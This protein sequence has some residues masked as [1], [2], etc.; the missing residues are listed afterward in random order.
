MKANTLLL[1]IPLAIILVMHSIPGMLDGGIKQFGTMFLN[2]LCFSP[3][4]IY[5]ASLIKLSHV[6]A[7]IAL[8]LN[9]YLRPAA[10]GTIFVLFVGIITVHLES[11][12]FVVG[13]GSNGVE[14]NFLLIFVWLYLIF[15][16]GR[17]QQ[18][19]T[20]RSFFTLW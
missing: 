7:A 17:G 4:G 20:Y 14:Y 2:P 8:I 18:K 16:G 12:W 1:R 3:L 10:W 15:S 9:K 5:L 6:G 19:P 13:G 11:G